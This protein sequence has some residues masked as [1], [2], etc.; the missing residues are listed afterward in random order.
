MSSNAAEF[1][2]SGAPN[3]RVKTSRKLEWDDL[4]NS[5][6]IN[7]APMSVSI[8]TCTPEAAP[9]KARKAE[10]GKTKKAG[11]RAE[12]GTAAGK[13]GKAAAKAA[14]Q[15]EGEKKPGAAGAAVKSAPKAAKAGKRAAAKACD[16]GETEES[17][18]VQGES[19]GTGCGQAGDCKS[20]RKAA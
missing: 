14:G 20:G 19:R 11:T 4:E 18:C 9:K 17:S 13:A 10:T 16:G 8:F 1:G 5:I 3:P 2:G 6:E 7:V 12:A 15:A